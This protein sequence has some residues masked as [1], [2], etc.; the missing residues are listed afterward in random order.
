MARPLERK[1]ERV[2]DIR[3]K[4]EDFS[5]IEQR[6]SAGKY[7]TSDEAEAAKRKKPRKASATPP[8]PCGSA[9]EPSS[10]FHAVIAAPL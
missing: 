2:I 6:N 9:A 7:S 10:H 3:D 5:K 8:A 1:V 4:D